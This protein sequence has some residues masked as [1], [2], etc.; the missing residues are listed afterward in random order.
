MGWTKLTSGTN[1]TLVSNTSLA[2]TC[3]P[4]AIGDLILVSSSPGQ[5][6]GG[7][8]ATGNMRDDLGNQYFL[9]ARTVDPTNHQLLEI[10]YS[11]VTVP[12]T[13]TVTTDYNPTPGTTVATNCSLNVDPFTG[14]N[15]GSVADGGAAQNQVGPGTGANAV[16]SGGFVTTATGDLLYGACVDTT[17]GADPGTPGTGFTSATVSGGV[18]LRSM[19]AVQGAQSTTSAVTLTATVGTDRFITGGQ[20][21]KAA[22]IGVSPTVGASS[23]PGRSP[24]K[25]PISLRFWQPAWGVAVASADLSLALTGVASTTGRGTV[26]VTHTNAL[27]GVSTTSAV[28]SV[29]ANTTKALSGVS[30][31]TGRGTLGVSRTKALSGVLSTTARGSVGSAR[32][33]PLTGVQASAAVGTV[34][35]TTGIVVALSGVAA[36]LAVGTLLPSVVAA[37]SGVQSTGLAGNLTVSGTDAVEQ[38]VSKFRYVIR[39]KGRMH[40]SSHREMSE[41]LDRIFATPDEPAA[42]A[43]LVEEVRAIVQ[44]FISKNELNLAKLEKDMQATRALLRLWEAETYRLREEGEDEDETVLLLS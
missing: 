9:G 44:P 17:T 43:P 35:A 2:A 40:K 37:I 6:A 31:T 19:Y 25:A 8:P 38:P 26:G 14:S 27:A 5:S 36:A 39:M 12:G 18:I 21:V 3:G 10:W 42:P 28:G 24:G 11:I 7:V 20:G 23:H 13:P 33:V 1:N 29:K 30:S 15:V 41:M 16:T 34:T 32:T 4:V 22:V